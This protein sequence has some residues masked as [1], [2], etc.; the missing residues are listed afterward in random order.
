MYY[1]VRVWEGDKL[2]YEQEFPPEIEENEDKALMNY[3]KMELLWPECKVS[4]TSQ[5]ISTYL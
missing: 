2:Q 5:A 1:I 3:D 4:F